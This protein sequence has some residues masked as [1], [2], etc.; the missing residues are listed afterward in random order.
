MAESILITGA[1]TGLGWLT[2]QTM[3]D[4][5]STDYARLKPD[6]DQY[7][8][9][10]KNLFEGREQPAH[11]VTDFVTQYETAQPSGNMGLRHLLHT[12]MKPTAA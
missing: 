4:K 5:G 12:K 8:P 9:G 10:L 1:G 7:G 3:F 6:F 2:A 11:A